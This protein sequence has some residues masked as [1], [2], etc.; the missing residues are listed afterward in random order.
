[1]YISVQTIETHRANLM[2][3]L[4]VHNVA[5][6]VLFAVRSGLVKV[7]MTASSAGWFRSGLFLSKAGGSRAFHDEVDEAKD[8]CGS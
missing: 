8:G 2:S 1:V 6:L 7:L 5:G 4:G 3:K